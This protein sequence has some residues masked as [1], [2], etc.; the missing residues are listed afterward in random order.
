MAV[1]KKCGFNI[2]EIH[3]DNE[4]YK[5]MDQFLQGQDPPIKINYAAAQEHVP[6]AEKKNRVIQ[7]CIQAAYHRFPFTHLPHIL[8]KYIDIESTK[9]LGFSNKHVVSKYFSPCMIMHQ[10]NWNTNVTA[11]IILENICKLMTSRSIKTRMRPYH[12]IVFIYARW[13]IAREATNYYIY[14]PKRL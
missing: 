6:W 7:E 4:F 8:V 10:K 1:Y 5:V 12:W 11:N 14:K 9:R 3:C 13:T 2:T